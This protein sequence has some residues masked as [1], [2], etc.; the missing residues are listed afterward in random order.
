MNTIFTLNQLSTLQQSGMVI[1]RGFTPPIISGHYILNSLKDS[2]GKVYE[3]FRCLFTNQTKEKDIY[4]SFIEKNINGG[5]LKGYIAGMNFNFSVFFQT[6]E[7]KRT[8]NQ[9]VI[10]SERQIR[11]ER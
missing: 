7:I 4:V 6:I 2:D 11:R 3:S 8:V 1:N 5:S 9:G 10:R